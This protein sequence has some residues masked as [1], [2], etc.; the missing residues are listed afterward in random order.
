LGYSTDATDTEALRSRSQ[1]LRQWE[2]I[3]E[4]QKSKA[5]IYS[6]TVELD[7]QNQPYR[8]RGGVYVSNTVALEFSGNERGL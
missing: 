6:D 5:Q 2:R 1:E 7:D 4:E 3:P 8:A